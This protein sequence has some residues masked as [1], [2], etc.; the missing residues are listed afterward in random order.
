VP[1]PREIVVAARH[2]VLQRD[3]LARG[4]EHSK[5]CRRSR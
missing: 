2:H 5:R 4:D 3:E 1:E